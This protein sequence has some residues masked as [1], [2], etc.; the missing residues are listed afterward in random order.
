MVVDSDG[1]A[2]SMTIGR[3]IVGRVWKKSVF[4]VLGRR[5]RY[6]HGCIQQSDSFTV[7]APRLGQLKEELLYCSTT[8]GRDFDQATEYP[9][10]LIPRKTVSTPVIE[11]CALHYECRIVVRKQL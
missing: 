10:T 5:S 1:K 6:T 4:V 2:N 3:G 9:L 11:E 8:S 7:N